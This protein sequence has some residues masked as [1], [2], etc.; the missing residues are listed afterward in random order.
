MFFLVKFKRY[1]QA[2]TSFDKPVIIVNEDE[3]IAREKAFQKR[4]KFGNLRLENVRDFGFASS[5]KFIWE[6]MSVKLG[7]RM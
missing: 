4:K 1:R 6:M 5:R 2:Q 3:A 7:E